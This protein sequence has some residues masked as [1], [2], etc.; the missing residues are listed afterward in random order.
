M[1]AAVS[2]TIGNETGDM[3]AT[4][5]ENRPTE[6]L[7]TETHEMYEILVN[8]PIIVAKSETFGIHETETCATREILETH[9]IFAIVTPEIC[10]VL[11]TQEILET[12]GSRTRHDDLTIGDSTRARTRALIRDPVEGHHLLKYPRRRLL[13][14]NV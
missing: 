5:I 11:V 1:T 10:A 6:I 2:G 8:L 14:G 9:G 4:T 13:Q 3:T 12:A 7:A